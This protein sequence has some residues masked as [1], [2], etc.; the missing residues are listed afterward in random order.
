MYKWAPNMK[1]LVKV[2]NTDVID[3]A[4]VALSL[5]TP[6]DC[7]IPIWKQLCEEKKDTVVQ[8]TLPSR[9]YGIW[10]NNK[11]YGA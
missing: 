1:I 10:Q 11:D 9:F 3:T 4:A 7:L 5:P 2:F 8:N 6:T